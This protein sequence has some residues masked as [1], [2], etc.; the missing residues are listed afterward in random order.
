[1]T[2]KRGETFERT[3]FKDGV[4]RG[5]MNDGFSIDVHFVPLPPQR[6]PTYTAGTQYKYM[7]QPPT[8]R[9]CA[10]AP[11]SGLSP[12]IPLRTLVLDKWNQ[13]CIQL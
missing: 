13:G 4:T 8:V 3:Y 1:M 11:N 12:V 10:H 6:S 9:A 5:K 7:R 2:L